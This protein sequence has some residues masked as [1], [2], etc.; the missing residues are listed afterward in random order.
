MDVVYL[1]HKAI[2]G[3]LH[4]RQDSCNTFAIQLTQNPSI[5]AVTHHAMAYSRRQVKPLPFQT[6]TN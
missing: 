2:N 5:F 6:D 4:N 3:L 1:N